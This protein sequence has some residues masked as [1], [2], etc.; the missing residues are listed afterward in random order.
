MNVTGELQSPTQTEGVTLIGD[1]G[2]RRGLARER[3][4]R[5][6]GTEAPVMCT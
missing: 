1:E 6:V 4:E 3:P 2:R 5:M